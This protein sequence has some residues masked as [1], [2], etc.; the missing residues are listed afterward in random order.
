MAFG[1]GASV[2]QVIDAAFDVTVGWLEK[3]S[4]LG[5]QIPTSSLYGYLRP[6]AFVASSWSERCQIL[7]VAFLC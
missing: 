2:S 5:P 7:H 3:V 6:M 4:L 1:S